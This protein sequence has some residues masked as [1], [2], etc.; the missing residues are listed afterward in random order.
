MEWIT[1]FSPHHTSK[2]SSLSLISTIRTPA[3][4]VPYIAVARLPRNRRPSIYIITSKHNLC[5]ACLNQMLFLSHLRIILH[6]IL[7]SHNQTL[8]GVLVKKFYIL[9]RKA[10]LLDSPEN[11]VWKRTVYNVMNAVRVLDNISQRF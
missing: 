11:S 7:C 3:Q 6:Q 8:T 9:F 5:C 1:E 4:Y 2:T 10:T